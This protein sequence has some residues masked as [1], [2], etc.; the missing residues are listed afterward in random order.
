MSDPVASALEVYWR[1]FEG[2]NS[3]DPVRV[4][5]ALNYPH[6][7]V[8]ARG[9]TGIVP[10]R[11][12]HAGKMTFDALLETGW[13]HTVGVEPEVLHESSDKV[14]LRGGW[15]RYDSDIKPIMTNAVTYIVTLVEGRWG[16]QS[17]FGTDS[18]LFWGRPE[19]R[20]VEGRFDLP[21][22]TREATQ[23]VVAALEATGVDAIPQFHFPCFFVQPGNVELIADP[24][25]LGRM[26]PGEI[27]E[28]NDVEAVQT[29]AT[30]AVVS[31]TASTGG[32]EIQ[33]V[34][35]VKIE[36]NRWGIKGA[37]LITS[38]R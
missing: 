3:R 28:I 20:P 1:F 13:D 12:T 18:E 7:R 31:C 22:N 34:L 16:F 36:N 38:K 19:D 5:D 35:M 11:E 27:F 23:V 26:L 37:S 4:V 21:A 33:G 32:E 6:V 9:E 10:D 17:R 8:G 30:G 24:A 25:E 2:T 15:T 14:H 29:G